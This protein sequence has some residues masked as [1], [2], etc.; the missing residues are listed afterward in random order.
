MRFY[1][2][3][4]ASFFGGL[5][6]KTTSRGRQRL[7]CYGW[8]GGYVGGRRRTTFA[9]VT[10]GGVVVAR[11]GRW[12]S[13]HLNNIILVLEVSK[14]HCFNVVKKMVEPFDS[15][16]IDRFVR[17]ASRS[18]SLLGLIP[19]QPFSVWFIGPNQ[20]HDWLTVKL[21]EPTNPIWF[22]RP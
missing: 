20:N 17:F 13:R 19:I 1:L 21:V 8:V 11:K 22:L 6:G 4:L 14:W 12:F 15:E 5:G 10:I 2:R 18:A 3:R 7:V 16:E 9:R